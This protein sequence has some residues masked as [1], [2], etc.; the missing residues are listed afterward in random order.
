MTEPTASILSAS[1]RA[2]LWMIELYPKKFRSEFGPELV[3]TFRDAI[4]E[5]F[6]H[7][8]AWALLPFWAETALD[9]AA[10][11]SIEH[12]KHR[13]AIDPFEK[14]LRWDLRYGLQS[15]LRHSQQVLQYL[16][17][18]AFLIPLATM[19]GSVVYV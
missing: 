9:L 13:K 7:G 4:H 12:L 19:F 18:A 11:V 16:L 15:F 3:Q 8:G 17:A 1:E 2:Y 14:D 5:Q 6:S 10:T